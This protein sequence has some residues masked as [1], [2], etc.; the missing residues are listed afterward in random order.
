M[1]QGNPTNIL[2]F[3]GGLGIVALIVVMVVVP[4]LGRLTLIIEAGSLLAGGLGEY[5]GNSHV[6]W[7]GCVV[8]ILIILSCCCIVVVGAGAILSCGTTNPSQL[9]RLVGR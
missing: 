6:V 5:F 8:V 3:L 9:C 7:I 2:L 1:L 4:L